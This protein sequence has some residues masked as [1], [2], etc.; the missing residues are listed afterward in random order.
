M[1]VKYTSLFLL[2]SILAELEIFI[3]EIDNLSLVE[4]NLKTHTYANILI[5]RQ[6][7]SPFLNRIKIKCNFK[8]SVWVTGYQDGSGT[9]YRKERKQQDRKPSTSSQD[10]LL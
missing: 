6:R 8:V 3:S 10:L 2:S 1:L 4:E 7:K 5:R 9:E